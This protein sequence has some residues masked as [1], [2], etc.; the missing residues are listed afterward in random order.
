MWHR[1]PRYSTP[2]GSVL[3]SR[4]LPSWGWLVLP[5]GR[6]WPLWCWSPW[7]RCGLQLQ[8]SAGVAKAMVPG[9]VGAPGLSSK[10]S[11]TASPDSWCSGCTA[12]EKACLGPCL[13][14][15]RAAFASL[16]SH[17][18]RTSLGSWQAS[19][20]AK[21][22][23]SWHIIFVGIIPRGSQKPK[24]PVAAGAGQSCWGS[25][26]CPCVRAAPGWGS[27]GRGDHVVGWSGCSS[28]SPLKPVNKAPAPLDYGGFC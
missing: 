22:W 5:S 1:V 26:R 15:G 28:W 10:D 4:Q 25:R 14:V 27:C 21:S 3:C 9:A 16:F 23:L 17:V 20:R 13:P 6:S 18:L 2:A 7:A 24:A 19:S 12:W 8:S 11:N